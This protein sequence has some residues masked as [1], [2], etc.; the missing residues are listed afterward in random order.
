MAFINVGCFADNWGLA[1]LQV[2][3]VRSVDDQVGFLLFYNVDIVSDV[4]MHFIV[5]N[6]DLFFILLQVHQ[7]IKGSSAHRSQL[8]KHDILS[9][10]LEVLMF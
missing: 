3:N 8:A 2:H 1:C 7:N 5:R 4:N 10:S 9:E 6:I